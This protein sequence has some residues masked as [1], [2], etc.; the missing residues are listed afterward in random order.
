MLETAAREPQRSAPAVSLRPA[1]EAVDVERRYRNGRGVGPITLCAT[2]GERLA[3]M[4]PNGAGK[5]TLLQVLATA[6]RP[7]RGSVRWYGLAAPRRA[8]RLIGVAP[9]TALEEGTL[10][11]RQSTYFWC[12]QW[13]PRAVARGLV[14]DVLKQFGLSAVA[15][16]PVAS[17]SFG[18]RRR[19]ALAQALVHIPR[20]ALLDEPTAGLDP[21]GVSALSGAMRARA[22]HGQLTVVASNDCDFVAASCDRVLFL[23]AG[24]LVHDAS[25]AALLARVGSSR[26][27]ELEVDGRCSID[28]LRRVRGVGAVEVSGGVVRVELR[29]ERALAGVVSAADGDGGGL[30]ALRVHTPNLG[31]AFLGLT[32]RK[33]DASPARE[34]RR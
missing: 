9:D 30:L 13:R 29:D 14:D 2:R 18:M 4:G 33:L 28:L 1:I 3:L 25:P 23:D 26:V 8:R 12:R 7:R 16:E 27:A 31:D 17:F 15:D 22:E 24:M 19:L 11:A 34:V 5:T 21:E 32:G 6:A 10:T 20:L